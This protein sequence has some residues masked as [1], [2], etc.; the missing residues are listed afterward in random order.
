VKPAEEPNAVKPEPPIDLRELSEEDATAYLDLV[1]RNRHYLQ[2][3][4]PRR[5]ESW[6]SREGVTAELAR[7]VEDRRLDWGFA[8]GIWERAT[9]ELVGRVALSTVVRG[10]WQN[11]NV[12][13]F[14]AEDRGGRGYAT[15]AVR[16]ALAFGFGWAELHRVQA[17][18]M[19]HNQRSIRVVEKNGFRRE[20]LARGY[21][22]IDGRWEDHLIYAITAEEWADRGTGSPRADGP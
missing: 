3:F 8:F 12:G 21:L 13:Y 17:A 5:P 7:S 19:P 15:W 14:V 11:A 18:V 6:F 16:E 9:G 10:A 2:P 22:R 20:G 1:L 4:E